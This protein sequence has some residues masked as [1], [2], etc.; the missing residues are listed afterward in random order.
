LAVTTTKS[1]IDP[2]YGHKARRPIR[3]PVSLAP[4]DLARSERP[5]F[6]VRRYVLADNPKGLV[7]HDLGD[8][9]SPHIAPFVN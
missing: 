1:S 5:A 3:E 4:D 2:R 7:A 6:V 9:R 8:R